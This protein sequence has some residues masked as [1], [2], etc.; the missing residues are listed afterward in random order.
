MKQIVHLFAVFILFCGV[1]EAVDF[2]E[3]KKI[4]LKKDETKKFLVKY[5]SRERLFTFRWTLYV[6]GGLVVFRSYDKRVAQNI[7]Y[8]NHTNQSFRV[9]LKT[10]GGDNYLVPY[11]LVKFKKFDFEKNEAMFDLLL[12]DVKM[13]VSLEDL[14]KK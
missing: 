3:V 9:E 4:S 13:Q 6:N 8:L 12:S 7:L 11:L 2:R 14:S 1:V 5:G 10:R